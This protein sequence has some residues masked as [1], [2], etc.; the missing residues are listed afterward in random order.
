MKIHSKL[1][2]L[3]ATMALGVAPAV[4]LATGSPSTTPPSNQGTL[5]SPPHP[6]RFC[7]PTMCWLASAATNSRSCCPPAPKPGGGAVLDR[8]RAQMPTPHTCSVGIATWDRAELADR[9]MVRADNA[10]YDAKRT[11]HDHPAETPVVSRVPRS[12]ASYAH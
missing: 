10:L 1:L 8:L 3:I 12:H 7:V 5:T 6:P 4:A 9:L 2:M 11:G